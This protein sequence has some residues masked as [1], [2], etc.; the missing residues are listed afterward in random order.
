M[1]TAAALLKR[2]VSKTGIGAQLGAILAA[3]V[4]F[5]VFLVL[6]GKSPWGVLADMGIGAFGSS[7]AWQNTLVRAAPLL[8]T[9]LC[10]LIPAQLGLVIIGNEGAWLLGG[11]ATSVLGASLPPSWGIG[12]L[13]LSLAAAAVA[14]GFWIGLAGAGRQWRGVDPTISSLLLYY[15]AW[16]VFLFL[17]EGP[18]RDPQ[19]LN[20]PSTFPLPKEFLMSSLPGTSVHAGLL[21][22]I[23]A[24][25]LAWFVFFRTRLGFDARIVGENERLGA[26]LGLRRSLLVVGACAVGGACAGLA[27]GIQIAAINHASNASLNAG[28]GFSGILV[29]FLARQRPLAVLLVALLVGGLQA[30]GG[31]VQRD[32]NLPDATISVFQGLLFL[33]VLWAEAFRRDPSGGNK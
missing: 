15:V 2:N 9:A 5:A 20:E 12:G 32:H 27:G 1:V 17:V 31:F 30:S 23:A 4:L 24:C 8:L 28:V 25:L 19:S 13:L 3:V 11:L 14:G 18:L 10:T 21:V 6:Q 29:A 7:F 22:G 33:S 26:T 16:G